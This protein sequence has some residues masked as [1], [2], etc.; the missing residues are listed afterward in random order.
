[1]QKLLWPTFL[2]D[3]QLVDQGWRWGTNGPLLSLNEELTR[4]TQIST[5]APL[6]LINS[7][8]SYDHSRGCFFFFFLSL[9]S[10]L[11]II[12][13]AR[14]LW[15]NRDFFFSESLNNS[16]RGKN[17]FIYTG[18][19]QTAFWTL[20]AAFFKEAEIR[21]SLHA[22]H[23]WRKVRGVKPQ[24]DLSVWDPVDQKSQGYLQRNQLASC[25]LI[26]NRATKSSSF[27]KRQKSLDYYYVNAVSLK[28]N[29][30]TCPLVTMT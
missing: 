19:N 22:W 5:W 12:R 26:R 10:S 15:L 27:V 6:H 11:Y 14:L 3:Y 16:K 20:N 9:F 2:D 4:V 24:L 17:A 29:V 25:C 30:Y 18:Q 1:M 13:R 21:N 28:T 7:L 8:E 23:V